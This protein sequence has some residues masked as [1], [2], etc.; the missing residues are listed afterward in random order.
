MAICLESCPQDLTLSEED[1]SCN[2]SMTGKKKPDL[3]RSQRALGSL[4]NVGTLLT[5]N[6]FSL[7]ASNSLYC[8][9]DLHNRYIT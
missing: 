4:N 1:D 2:H 5:R 8:F 3:G 9:F 7:L 6:Y